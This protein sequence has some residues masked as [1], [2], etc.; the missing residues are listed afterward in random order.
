MFANGMSWAVLITPYME[1]YN[2]WE[3]FYLWDQYT[4]FNNW[5]N[6]DDDNAAFPYLYCPSRR[7]SPQYVQWD[8]STY[9]L[10]GTQTNYSGKLVVAD[11][12]MPGV[13]ATSTDDFTNTSSWA[14]ARS[15]TN[16]L[17]P[18]LTVWPTEADMPNTATETARRYRSKTSFASWT[19]GTVNQAVFGEKAAHPQY[20]GQPGQW[21]DSSVY[22]WL[23]GTQN[24]GGVIR[25][26]W[27]A[28]A[29]HARDTR[30][31][32]LFQMFGSWH[33]NIFQMSFGDGRVVAINSWVGSGMLYYLCNRA[34]GART[35]LVGK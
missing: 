6:I 10:Q 18:F 2:F 16:Q 8:Y 24:V 31:G 19:D 26:G 27:E 34:D 9:N 32:R 33:P 23:P 35:N 17:G 25:D 4:V 13:G 30:S 3:D 5:S 20:V 28:P 12:A 14:Y 11:Y 21:G 7:S 15:L 29:R 1:N 22:I